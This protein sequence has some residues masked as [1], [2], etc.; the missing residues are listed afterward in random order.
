MHFGK[1]GRSMP[2]SIFTVLSDLSVK[3]FV[4]YVE[5]L[6]HDLLVMLDLFLVV[7]QPSSCC[8]YLVVCGEERLAEFMGADV[9]VEALVTNSFVGCVGWLAVIH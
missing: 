1:H 3:Y 6:V 9:L 4:A 2:V 8:K 5:V 7:L